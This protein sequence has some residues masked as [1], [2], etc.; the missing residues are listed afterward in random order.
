M[1]NKT[2]DAIC[3]YGASSSI[4]DPCYTDDGRQLG[5]LIAL[6]GHPLVCGGGKAGIMKAAI[7][8]AIAEGGKT[9]GVLPEFMMKNSW[10]HPDLSEVIVTRNLQG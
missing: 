1:E 2:T 10:Q 3:V 4:I 7:E 8:G 6:S 9:I 5:R